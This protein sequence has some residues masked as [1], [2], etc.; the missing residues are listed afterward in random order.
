MSAQHPLYQTILTQLTA[1]IPAHAVP[2]PLVVR[3][4][5]LVTGLLAASST[6]RAHWAPG[7]P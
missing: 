1:T 3:L 4:A 2:R 5:V 7:R 6:L